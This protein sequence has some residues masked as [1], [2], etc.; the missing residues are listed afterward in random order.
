MSKRTTS[1]VWEAVVSL[2]VF[3]AH[4][5]KS[6]GS[7]KK[8][9]DFLHRHRVFMSAYIN[10]EA[11]FRSVPIHVSSP[12]V[13]ISDYVWICTSNSWNDE[14]WP[15]RAYS[16]KH[17]R[18]GEKKCYWIMNSTL[19]VFIAIYSSMLHEKDWVFLL[20]S[21]HVDL[22][23]SFLCPFLKWHPKI[24]LQQM[25]SCV[26]KTKQKVVKN[27]LFVLAE[28]ST[29]QRRGPTSKTH[30]TDLQRWVFHLP[31]PFS[32]QTGEEVAFLLTF[33]RSFVLHPTD[34]WLLIFFWLYS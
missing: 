7:R 34:S 19:N 12:A 24:I 10:L 27:E 4:T 6:L 8:C 18:E 15:V 14:V 2:S 11:A 26:L 32:S 21:K 31:N 1:W 22:S 13:Y 20:V 23:A 29:C 30:Q 16:Q 25:C 3:Q 33:H 17:K 28:G 9:A 5:E